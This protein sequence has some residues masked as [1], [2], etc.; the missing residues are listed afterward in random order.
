MKK[1]AVALAL[2]AAFICTAGAANVGTIDNEYPGDTEAQAQML[3]DLGLF[4]GTD[5]GFELEKPMTRVEAAVMLT[6]LLGAEREALAG[7]RAHPFYDVPQWAEPYVGWLYENG[8]TK[9]V[10]ATQY[11]ARQRVTCGQYTLF[12]ARALNGGEEYGGVADD[13]EIAAC[14]AAGFV[15]G[16]A[17]SLS[18]RALDRIY[19]EQAPMR[20]GFT[21]ACR[22]T[23]QG[24]FTPETLKNAAWHVLPRAVQWVDENGEPFGEQGDLCCLIAGVPVLRNTETDV[25][26]DRDLSDETGR[27]YGFSIDETTHQRII[28]AIDPETLQTTRLFA[29]AD[30][31]GVYAVYSTEK[32]DYFRAGTRLL[33]VSG[34]AVKE[35][36]ITFDAKDTLLVSASDEKGRCAFTCK[37]GICVIDGD[38]V[39]TIGEPGIGMLYG[40]I[41]GLLIAQN[42]AKEQTNIS[43]WMWDGCAAGDYTVAN[44][45]PPELA[46][47]SLLYA[48]RVERSDETY[49][50]GGAGLYQVEND[51]LIQRIAR[52]VYGWAQ[53]ETDNSYVLITHD[54]EKR[55]EYTEYAVPVQTGDTLVRMHADGTETPLLPELPEGSLLLGEVLDAQDGKVT[56]TTLKAAEPHYMSQFTCVLENGRIRVTEADA[57]ITMIYGENAA[58]KEQA[59]LDALGVGAA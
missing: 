17:V 43:A 44:H 13:A 10:S 25:R 37:Q 59:R 4:R 2:F 46:D 7:T 39:R 31:E 23:E 5:K 21:L 29:C 35:E 32:Y 58:A 57:G 27:E 56:F 19:T 6:R 38:R 14:D 9:G 8:L 42:V 16:D 36:K 26:H 30:T 48:P 49:L 1:L 55:V 40:Q 24:V 3:F 12:L 53:D 41:G 34:T 54:A 52:P 51:R 18:V 50:W 28:H 11:G 45:C 47:S 15:R 20:S 33:S 22:L